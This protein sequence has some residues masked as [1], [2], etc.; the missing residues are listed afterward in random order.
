MFNSFP[1]LMLKENRKVLSDEDARLWIKVAMET[2]KLCLY[3]LYAFEKWRENTPMLDSVILDVIAL[4]GERENLERLAEGYLKEGK[5]SLLMYDGETHLLIVEHDGTPLEKVVDPQGTKVIRDVL[6]KFTYPNTP[7]G[8]TRVKAQLI[9][10][11]KS[12]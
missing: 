5:Q 10:R 9:R 1:R 2:G 4:Q 7:N 3:G 12:E 8:K 11:Y 6:Y